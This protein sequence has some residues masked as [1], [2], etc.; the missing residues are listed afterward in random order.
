MA[1]YPKMSAEE[2][3]AELSEVRARYAAIQAMRLS[4]N[5]ARGKPAPAQLDL[6]TPLLTILQA[7]EDCFS[8]DGTDCRNYGV[9]DGIP[10]AK[11]LMTRLL[12]DEPG[13][14]FVFGNASLTIMHDAIARCLDFG[15]LGSAPWSALDGP[16]RFLCPVPGYD[17]HFAILEQFGIEMIPVPMTATGPDMDEV[18]RIAGSDESVKG[19]WCVPKY[20]NPTGITY[21]D[22]TVRRLA[23]MAC[24]AAD[25]RIFWDNAYCVHHLYPE[26]ELQDSVLDIGIACMEAGNPDRYLKFASTSKITFPGAGVAAMAASPA[27]IAE[28]KRL[29]GA[30][31]IGH[32][33]LNQLRHARFL[34]SEE[35]LAAHMDAQADIIRPKFQLVERILDEELGGLEIASWTDPRGGYFVSFDGLPGTAARTVQLA[36]EAGVILTDAGATWPYGM[37]PKDANIRIAP[38]MPTLEELEQAMVAFCC[39]A[40]M[41]ALEALEQ[42]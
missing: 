41:A 6:S 38:T 33:K 18:E 23:K 9:I 13:N 30:Q 20:S 40:K 35:A 17:R 1:S 34:P 24:A 29:C 10:E 19:I 21:S 32:D 39:C 11:R 25:F 16:V 3:A 27:N 22:E 31:M 36:K 14:V 8:E 5:M 42:R 12:D 4:L 15:C 26:P 7:R 28:A 37:D 2:R